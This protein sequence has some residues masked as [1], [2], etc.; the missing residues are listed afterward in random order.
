[1]VH[2]FL[3]IDPITMA[4]IKARSFSTLRTSYSTLFAIFSFSATAMLEVVDRS[5]L[6]INFAFGFF[7]QTTDFKSSAP[8]V[9]LARYFY[10]PHL[11]VIIISPDNNMQLFQNS[12]DVF[13]KESL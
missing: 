4:K 11:Q 5:S 1:M 2:S 3:W 7:E 12:C 9:L 8:V 6:I 13:T 10:N